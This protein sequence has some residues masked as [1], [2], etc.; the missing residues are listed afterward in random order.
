MVEINHKET[1]MFFFTTTINSPLP[2]NIVSCSFIIL[3]I[4]F[5]CQAMTCTCA[6]SYLISHLWANLNKVT[7]EFPTL[8]DDSPL[9]KQ[10]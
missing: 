10:I 4:A 7:V 9:F 6:L 2:D 3:Q 8:T 5:D 1:Y